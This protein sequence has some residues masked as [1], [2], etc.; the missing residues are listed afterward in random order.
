MDENFQTSVKNM[1]TAA[2]YS[3]NL[4]KGLHEVCKALESDDKPE[5]CLLAEDC[6]E[7]QYKKLVTALC[8]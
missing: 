5:V 6:K 3:N 1:L 4:S 2:R 8:N 7:E